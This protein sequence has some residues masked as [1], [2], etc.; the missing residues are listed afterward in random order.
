MHL[1]S[2]MRYLHCLRL[3]P[4]PRLVNRVPMGCSDYPRY[5]TDIAQWTSALQTLSMITNNIRMSKL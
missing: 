2:M 1:S 3:V 5:Q 4:R